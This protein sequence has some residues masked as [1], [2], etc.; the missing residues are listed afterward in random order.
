MQYAKMSKT[1]HIRCRIE[2]KVRETHAE[3]ILT[4]K[5]V[6][7]KKNPQ[8]YYRINCALSAIMF[9]IQWSR[10]SVEKI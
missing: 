6:N 2:K 1:F 3:R 5:S 10:Q 4:T 9:L 7:D 8:V